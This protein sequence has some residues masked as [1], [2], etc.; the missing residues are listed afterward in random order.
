MA[1]ERREHEVYR[2]EVLKTHEEEESKSQ[3]STDDMAPDKEIATVE[4]CEKE[5]QT[6][7]VNIKSFREM[8]EAQQTEFETNVEEEK[9]TIETI[10]IISMDE[11]G[12]V[13]D[14]FTFEP[15]KGEEMNFYNERRV[16]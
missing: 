9:E 3:V 11:I 4:V 16:Y 15:Q 5:I 2:T 6:S 10:D 8:V 7:E 13:E 1:E 12:F 14:E